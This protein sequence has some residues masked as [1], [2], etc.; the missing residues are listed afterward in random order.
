MEL[1][2]AIATAEKLKDA[3]VSEVERAREE[4]LLL[5]NLD[6]E[7]LLRRA[8]LRDG[9]NIA[10]VALQRALQR[11]LAGAAKRLSLTE[12]TLPALAAQV[13]TEAAQL[14]G[15]LAQV[16]L[17]SSTLAELDALNRSLGERTLSVV[18]SY[19][20]AVVPKA[21]S[22]GPQGQ[23]AAAGALSATVSTRA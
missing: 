2:P 1:T 13:P 19:L 21:A 8:A 11:D 14:S 22:Y 16:R 15:V 6:G 23:Q 12:V 17:L 10:C 9:F 18:R 20:A 7:A 3:L 4:R 5:R